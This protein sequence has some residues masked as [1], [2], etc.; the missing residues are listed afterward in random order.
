M[1]R[2]QEKAVG[3]DVLNSLTPGQTVI[4][5]VYEELREM[6]GGEATQ[7]VL[8]NE[9]NVWF[10]VGLQGAGKT[11]TTGKLESWSGRWCSDG[12]VWTG[13]V[14]V[15]PTPATQETKALLEQPN[16]RPRAVSQTPP[17]RAVESPHV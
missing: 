13:L 4:K 14:P 11:T 15:R 2:V 16:P 3:Q 17:P 1:A 8:K 7:P 9:R 12:A 6:L 10:M 5:I